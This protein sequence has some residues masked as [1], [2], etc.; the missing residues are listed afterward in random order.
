MQRT[1]QQQLE[2]AEADYECEVQRQQNTS[3]D[4]LRAREQA[5]ALQEE[6]AN[7]QQQLRV[8]QAEQCRWQA[9]RQDLQAELTAARHEGHTAKTTSTHLHERAALLEGQLQQ[10]EAEML[11]REKLGLPDQITRLQTELRRKNT[12]IASLQATETAHSELVAR[13]G[14]LVDQVGHESPACDLN[15]SMATM[16]RVGSM[17]HLQIRCD[18]LCGLV[19][20]ACIHAAGS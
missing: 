3:H 1:L 16:T 2:A 6:V 5:Q 18:M 15:G 8:L 20:A 13:H 12:Y 19:L 4:L 10:L 17:Q 14:V 11:A 9:E 7:L